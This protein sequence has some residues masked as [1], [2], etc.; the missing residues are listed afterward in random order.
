MLD[1]A[2]LKQ[3]REKKGLTQQAAADAAGL[4][5]RQA[6]HQIEAGLR[7][8]VTVETLNRLAAAVGVKAKDLLK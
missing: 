1:T 8:N 4:A 2:K 7:A 5:N 6:W 3:L